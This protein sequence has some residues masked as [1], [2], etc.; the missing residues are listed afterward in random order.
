MNKLILVTHEVQR[1]ISELHI[2]QANQNSDEFLPEKTEISCKTIKLTYTV[3]D[4]YVLRYQSDIKFS[5]PISI[6]WFF[7]L[8]SYKVSMVAQLI[9]C[10]TP[11]IRG[12]ANAILFEYT[13]SI[14]G[15]FDLVRWV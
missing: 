1:C 2:L 7:N 4:Y 9:R 15:S 11:S 12:E 13:P 3:V 14:I 10:S 5:C 8:S 6:K